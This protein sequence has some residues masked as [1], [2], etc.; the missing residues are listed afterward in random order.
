MKRYDH[1]RVKAREWRLAGSSIDDI[2]SRLSLSKGT[3]Y[4]WIKDIPLQRSKRGGENLR[5]GGPAHIAAAKKHKLR[6]ESAYVLGLSEYDSLM[7]APSFRDFVTLFMTEGYRRGKNVVSVAN[8][9]HT[10]IRLACFWLRKLSNKRL[11]AAFQHYA[12]QDP[13][14]LRRYWSEVTGIDASEIK[15]SLKTNA[16]GLQ[17][18]NNRCVN[19]VLTIAVYDTQMRNRMLGWC[20]RIEQEWITLNQS[21]DHAE[22][23]LIWDQENRE[24]SNPSALTN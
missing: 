10:L 15:S 4:H 23:H 12:D 22:G 19:G 21:E 18:R 20:E 3:V 14:V 24:G 17:G 5:K 2:C 7:S 16:G 1:L 11:R 6:R 9:N 8:S 13:E